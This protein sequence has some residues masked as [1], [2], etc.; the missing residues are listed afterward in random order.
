[1]KPF[2]SESNLSAKTTITTNR[3]QIFKRKWLS[4]CLT[5]KEMWNTELLTG[6]DT[7]PLSGWDDR[8]KSKKE[9]GGNLGLPNL[10]SS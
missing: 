4:K 5:S 6:K 9:F 2:N 1:M 7:S 10:R 3:M 8:T